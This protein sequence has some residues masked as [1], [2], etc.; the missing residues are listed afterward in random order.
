VLIV[1]WGSTTGSIRDALDRIDPQ[2]QNYSFLQLRMMRPFPTSQVS[3]LLNTAAKVI[4]FDCNYSGQ[5]AALIRTETGFKVHHQVVKFDGRP[6]SE[7]EIIVAVEKA[8]AGAPER[9]IVSEGKVV[10]PEY[11]LEQ[12]NHMLELRN[13]RP[14]ML[15]PM[16]PLPP[17]YNK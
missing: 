10:P 6:F 4:S 8:V 15:A 13:K 3:E 2:H 11:G 7:E 12:F 14:K 1:A 5:I 16:V 17:G 9:L